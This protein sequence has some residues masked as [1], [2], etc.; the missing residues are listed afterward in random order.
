[1]CYSIH[2][3]IVE[4]CA[5]ELTGQRANASQVSVRN[6]ARHAFQLN[7]LLGQ[8]LSLVAHRLGLRSDPGSVVP[9]QIARVR[10]KF[11]VRWRHYSSRVSSRVPLVQTFAKWASGRAETRRAMAHLAAAADVREDA[12]R[13]SDIPSCASCAGEPRVLA[14]I[15]QDGFAFASDPQDASFFNR[16][17]RRL[18]RK[19]YQLH[20]VLRDGRVCLRKTFAKQP[21]SAG[22]RPWLWST[23]G[24]PFYTEAAALFRL[25]HVAGVPRLRAIDLATRTVHMDWIRGE[26]LRERLAQGPDAV[27]DLDLEHDPELSRLSLEGRDE[28]EIAL[29]RPRI[30][31]QTKRHLRDLIAEC[32]RAGVAVR[33][34][35]YGNVIIGHR[36][37]KAYW[38]DFETAQ[39]ESH[40]NWHQAVGFQNHELNRRFD[41]R[42][43]TAADIAAYSSSHEIHAPVDFGPL[44]PMADIADVEKGEGRWRWLLKDLADWRGKRI[45]DL[46]S[47]NCLNPF[48][49]LEAGASAVTCVEPDLGLCQQAEFVRTVLEQVSG[50]SLDAQIVNT[51]TL[52]F[53][54]SV[55][56]PDRH[57][58]LTTA[59]CSIYYLSHQ[60]IE[61]AMRIIARISKECWLQ[62]NVDAEREGPDLRERPT[63]SFL[64]EQLRAVGFTDIVEIAPPSYRCPLLL[65]RRPPG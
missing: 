26:T 22:L 30:E 64:A 40:P 49:Q 61:E 57:F 5:S 38:V 43:V 52:S 13:P 60:E 8:A 35:K 34:V 37:G 29:F 19:R 51:D 14:E 6:W 27:H 31:P 45:L 1:V 50:R 41:L 54:R 9:G 15:D 24:L 3:E 53:L 59:L 39:L 21:L 33:D 28:R 65:G 47:N 55:D 12:A 48:R 4:S 58:D 25:R 62:S 7:T 23:L 63:P 44:G 46:G 10:L 17:D 56:V 32:N 36:T 42:W 11:G 18:A 2:A 16:R 20:V